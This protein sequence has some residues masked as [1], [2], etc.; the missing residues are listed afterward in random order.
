MIKNFVLNYIRT[1][2]SHETMN[3]RAEIFQAIN[4]GCASAFTEDNLQTRI[5]WTVGELVRNDPEFCDRC[6]GG[7]GAE[8]RLYVSRATANEINVFRG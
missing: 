3:D 6:S 2:M 5:S 7:Q 1:H 8:L 4:E